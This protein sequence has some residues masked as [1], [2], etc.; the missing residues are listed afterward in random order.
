[1]AFLNCIG[2]LA[3]IK[4][5]E[6]HV[7]DPS[8][9]VVLPKPNRR[10]KDFIMKFAKTLLRERKER[11]YCDDVSVRMCVLHNGAAA[12][13]RLRGSGSL[14]LML[15]ITLLLYFG[16]SSGGVRGWVYKIEF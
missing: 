16:V 8:T 5:A 2:D 4:C 9:G 3:A 12:L 7:L 15:C 6:D 10:A 11:E 14:L 1:M 13:T